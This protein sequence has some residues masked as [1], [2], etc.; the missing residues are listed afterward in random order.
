MLQTPVFFFLLEVLA[1]GMENLDDIGVFQ[2]LGVMGDIALNAP[3]VPGLCDLSLPVDNELDFAGQK[4]SNLFLGMGVLSQFAALGQVELE[5][6]RLIAESEC[7]ETDAGAGF[8]EFGLTFFVEHAVAP[9]GK[10]V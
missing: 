3:A 5:H 10:G 4:V 8:L 9:L 7:L 2:G 1:L 6:L